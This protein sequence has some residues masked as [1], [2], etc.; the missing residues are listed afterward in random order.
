M[1][2]QQVLPY[3][4]SSFVAVQ[5][6]N[7][8]SITWNSASLGTQEENFR[9][10]SNGSSATHYSDDI[11]AHGVGTGKKCNIKSNYRHIPHIPHSVRP[12]FQVARRNARERRRVQSV[13]VAFSKL[14]QVVPTDFGESEGNTI[15]KTRGPAYEDVRAR[16]SSKVAILRRAIDYI[17]LLE[18][19]LLIQNQ[20]AVISYV[21]EI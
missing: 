13:N 18:E 2:D 10:Y 8:F 6:G 16:R 7:A 20:S 4:T 14:H 15:D 19:V 3:P 17:R 9:P 5:E 11:G 12:A 1:S 21:S